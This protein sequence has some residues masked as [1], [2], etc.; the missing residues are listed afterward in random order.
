MLNGEPDVIFNKVW[1]CQREIAIAAVGFEF[2]NIRALMFNAVGYPVCCM[3][4][5]AGDLP[6]LYCRTKYQ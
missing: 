2:A 1:F 4:N 3:L 6:R 5:A